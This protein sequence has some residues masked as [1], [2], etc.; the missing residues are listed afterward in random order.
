MDVYFQFRLFYKLYLASHN[1]K[2]IIE[3]WKVNHPKINNINEKH[4]LAFHIHK[5]SQKNEHNTNFFIGNAFFM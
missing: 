3:G 2:L 4:I 1:F 5:Q